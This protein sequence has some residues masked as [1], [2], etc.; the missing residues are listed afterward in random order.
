MICEYSVNGG[1]RARL[2]F[3][4]NGISTQEYNLPIGKGKMNIMKKY[5]YIHKTYAIIGVNGAVF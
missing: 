4:V 5:L 1:C 3:S 2:P